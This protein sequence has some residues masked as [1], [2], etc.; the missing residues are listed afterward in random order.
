MNTITIKQND[1]TKLT[2]YSNNCEHQI[3]NGL[4]EGNWIT[5]TYIGEL[6]GTDTKNVKVIKIQDD[7]ENKVEAEKKKMQMKAVDE[8]VY[9]TAGVHIRKSY[10]TNS[11]VVGSLAKGES[12][13]RTGV[14]ENGWSRVVYKNADAYIYGEYLT[15]NAPKAEAKPAKTN[16]EKPATPQNGNNPEPV[17][18]TKKQQ[19]EQEQPK[20]QQESVGTVVDVSM[21]TLT[22]KI[23]KETYTLNTIDAEHEYANGIQTGNTVKITYIGELKDPDVIVVKV[24]DDDPNTAAQNAEYTGTIVD[25]TLNTISIQM[26]DEA[27][28][29]FEMSEAEDHVGDLQMGMRVTIVTDMTKADAGES[30]LSAKE[31]NVG[32]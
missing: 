9:A 10:S 5:I 18:E 27:I 8:T 16:G 20:K 19:P 21:S 1:G 4:R 13:K 32:K 3:K 12:I 24:Q 6:K 26:D 17:Q 23:D 29:T 14:C 15:K 7:D 11:K 22:V 30:I 25:F 2:F 28:M 31:I